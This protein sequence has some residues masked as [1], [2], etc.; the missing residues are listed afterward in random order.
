MATDLTLHNEQGAGVRAQ[1]LTVRRG[2]EVLFK[3]L[4]FE[5][6]AGQLVWLR[7]SNGSGKTSLL[8]VIAGLSRPDGGQLSWGGQPLAQSEDYKARLVYMGHANALKDD[9]TALEALHFMT[10]VH[11]R[12]CSAERMEAALRRMGVHHRRKLPVRMLSQG[13]R[14]RVALARLALE[15]RPGFWVLDEPFDALDD[16]GLALVQQL[17]VENVQRGGTVLFTSHIPVRPDGV[18]LQELRL[19]GTRK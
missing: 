14:R 16:A 18:A 1:D 8:R 9:L 12:S 13:Q 3:A 10:T 17:F 7:G 5:L 4:N 6:Q 11:G 19:E 15:E 2:N